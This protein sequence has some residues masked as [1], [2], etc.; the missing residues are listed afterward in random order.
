MAAVMDMTGWHSCM[1]SW[2]LQGNMELCLVFRPH[3]KMQNRSG[4]SSRSAVLPSE[5]TPITERF[6]RQRRGLNYARLPD[7]C[8][9]YQV[10]AS[11][12]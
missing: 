10:L 8:Q 12:N 6:G 4:K 11:L 7:H 1:K 2:W 3:R 9:E 5:H